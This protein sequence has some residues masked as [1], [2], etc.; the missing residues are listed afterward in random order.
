[1]QIYVKQTSNCEA[2][3]LQTF[4]LLSPVWSGDKIR[5]P[6]GE[7]PVRLNVV[8]WTDLFNGQA[9]AVHVAKVRVN[10]A[11]GWLVWGG[12]SG[13]R[14]LDKRAPVTA[15]DAHLPPGYGRPIVW[16]ED[17]GDLPAAVRRA[18]ELEAE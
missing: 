18:L 1:M 2:M 11:V 14:I 5:L 10:G 7:P 17:A 3:P 6:F 13:V 12:N 4:E 16:L 15:W 9:C 8:G